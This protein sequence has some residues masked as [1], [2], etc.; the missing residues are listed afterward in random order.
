MRSV[1][2]SNQESCVGGRLTIYRMYHSVQGL[3]AEGQV[4]CPGGHCLNAGLEFQAAFDVQ[5]ELLM[6]RLAKAESCMSPKKSL[7]PERLLFSRC[8]WFPME[9]HRCRSCKV[10]KSLFVISASSLRHCSVSWDLPYP[11]SHIHQGRN[12]SPRYDFRGA[13]E[14][15]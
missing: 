5:G 11:F 4:V 13:W 14:E 9:N 3:S 12:L 1:C 15:E 6:G 10:G 2:L 8:P 7:P